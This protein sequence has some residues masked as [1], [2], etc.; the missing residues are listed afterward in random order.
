[1]IKTVSW[2]KVNRKGV[3][4]AIYECNKC[5]MSVKTSCAKCDEPS[6]DDILI[7]DNV[8]EV[9]ISKCPECEW[10]IKSPSCCGIEMVC[11]N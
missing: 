3:F 6:V 4:M 8:E 9:Q 10:K 2:F 1:M 5:G 7:L 11:N